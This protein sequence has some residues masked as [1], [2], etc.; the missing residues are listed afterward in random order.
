MKIGLVDS[1]IAFFIVKT[2]GKEIN[3]CKKYSPVGNLA[4]RAK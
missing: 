1:E 3:A 2:K 4:E